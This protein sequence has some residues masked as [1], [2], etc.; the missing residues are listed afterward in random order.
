MFDNVTFR[1]IKGIPIN[2]VETRTLAEMGFPVDV[3][4]ENKEHYDEKHYDRFYNKLDNSPLSTSGE[5]EKLYIQSLIETGEK[6]KSLLDVLLKLKLYNIE[7][8]ELVSVLKSSNIYTLTCEEA[9]LM[10]EQFV[11]MINELLPRQL[12]DIYYSFDLE[13]NFVYFIFFE[14]AAEK[15]NLQRY[16][17]P[18]DY[19]YRQFVSHM[20]DGVKRRIENGES[21]IY[22]YKN[23]CATKEIIKRVANTISK[24]MHVAVES[25]LFSLSK[26]YS[27]EK[28][29]I[30][31]SMHF[32]YLVYKDGVKILKVILLHVEDI[33]NIDSYEKY[34]LSFKE[35][36]IP[37]IVLDSYLFNGYN[38]SGIEGEDVFFSDIIRNAVKNPSSINEFME[39]RKKFFELE[40]F[41]Y[42]L[43]KSTEKNS[44][45]AHTAVLCGCISCGKIFAPEKIKKW[46]FDGPDSILGDACCPFCCDNMVIMDSQGYEITKTSID[47]LVCSL[48]DYDLYCY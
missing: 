47:D 10:L 43:L 33:P 21:L 8:E 23:T 22:I 3:S 20:C 35:D 38:F 6:D 12:S 5:I 29:E 27:Y 7:K 1:C 30:N 36:D 39:G 4:K 18:N 34:V 16:T 19:K 9:T 2:T 25:T 40:K 32:E 44:K 24:D 31:N 42:K 13:P 37:I 41:R 11:F 17:D 45:F 26:Q 48:N 28:K 14:L 46:R 15:L